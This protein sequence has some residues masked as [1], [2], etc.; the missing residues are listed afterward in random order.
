[1]VSLSIYCKVITYR[2]VLLKIFKNSAFSLLMC[3]V[4]IATK[5]NQ[6]FWQVSL[7]LALKCHWFISSDW[8]SNSTGKMAMG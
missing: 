5:V 1:M 3:S 4:A 2:L 6:V 7:L 8:N